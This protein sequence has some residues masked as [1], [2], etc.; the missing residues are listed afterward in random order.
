MILALIALNNSCFITLQGL[1]GAR[2]LEDIFGTSEHT[3]DGPQGCKLY[4]EMQVL[5]SVSWESQ[6]RGET[7]GQYPVQETGWCSVHFIYSKT[8]ILPRL[9]D[10]GCSC[11]SLTRLKKVLIAIFA[12][13]GPGEKF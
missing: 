9:V 7:G 3:T 4:G 5:D 2:L 11:S 12:F 13:F 8:G 1:S 6:D 10:C